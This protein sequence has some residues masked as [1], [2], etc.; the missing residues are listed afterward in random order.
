[1]TEKDYKIMLKDKLIE[2]RDTL[3][4]SSD[5]TFG[6]EIEYENIVKETISYLLEEEKFYNP[7]L[8]GWVNKSEFDIAEYNKSGEETNGEIVSKILTDRP[9]TWDC[10]RTILIMLDRNGAVITNK[11]GGHVNIGAHIL[12]KNKKYWRNFFLLWMLYEDVIYD[13][14][15]GEF[16]NFRVENNS[17]N[18]YVYRISGHFELNKILNLKQ[19]NYK[20][21]IYTSNLCLLDKFH[22]V[23]I[24]SM[25]GNEITNGN[26]IEFR[27]PNGTLNEE[28]WQN[29]INFF[30]KFVIA[31][32][33]ELDIDKTIFK[34]KNN[35][36]NAVELADYIFDDDI[37]KE[38]FLIQAL[39]TN[40]VYKKE[41]PGHI[42]Y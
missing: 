17:I 35:E 27:I 33:K 11:C 24:S 5:I 25:V 31:C 26:R 39:K 42:Y 28:I 19:K 7:R 1:M 9:S 6:I 40:K 10:L 2:Y 16:L 29:Y 4:L 23:Y 37:D 15:K 12:G 20:N 34:I 38:Y 8:V 13:F 3:N 22:D 21:Y 14:S 18:N 32:K 41:L 36:S 30:S